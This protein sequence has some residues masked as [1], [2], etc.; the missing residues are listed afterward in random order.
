MLRKSILALFGVCALFYGA[1][2]VD[3]AQNDPSRRFAFPHI[4]RGELGNGDT[5]TS[6][7]VFHN[8]SVDAC[9]LEV[10]LHDE[11]VTPLIQLLS[12]SVERTKATR[13][14]STFPPLI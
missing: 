10:L 6:Y 5:I 1:L 14:T 9:R 8:E 13:S 4:P 7:A 2:S 3:L 11:P 12:G